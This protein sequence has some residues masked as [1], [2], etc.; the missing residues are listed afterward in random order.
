MKEPLV[1]VI[2]VCPESSRNEA[3]LL[4]SPC[5]LCQVRE[6]N[7]A[8]TWRGAGAGGRSE[9]GGEGGRGSGDK[10]S[11]ASIQAD[12]R[13]PVD[14]RDGQQHHTTILGHVIL[15]KLCHIHKLI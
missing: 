5:W 9:D 6:T 15:V 1:H 2:H 12:L 13:I 7:E 8:D 3:Y 11:G 4:T 14:M 10:L